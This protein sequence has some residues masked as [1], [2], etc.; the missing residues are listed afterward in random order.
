MDWNEVFAEPGFTYGTEPNGYLRE[1]A[2][3]LTSPVLCLAEGEGR[4]SVYLASLGLEV[5]GVDGSA[6]GLAKARELAKERGVTITT[7]V[8]D[9]ATYDLGRERWGSIVSISAHLPPEIRARVHA[10]IGPAL[11]RDGVF[12]CEAYSPDQLGR[13]TGGPP[14]REWLFAIDRVRAEL[15]EHFDF[16]I[17]HE[18]EREVVEGRRHTGLASVTQILAVKRH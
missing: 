14:D 4:N 12:L 1:H 15:G 7:A 16:E 3:R 18:T 10:R 8:A 11:K 9:L 13:G 2:A 17:A 6:V 5:H